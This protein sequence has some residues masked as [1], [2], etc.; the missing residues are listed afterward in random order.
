MK[1]SMFHKMLLKNPNIVVVVPIYVLYIMSQGKHIQS[2]QIQ[3]QGL[4]PEKYW[5]F[6]IW[7]IRE[8]KTFHDGIPF[9]VGLVD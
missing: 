8:I 9:R 4:D 3:N 6:H 1:N 7:K 2:Q 5:I